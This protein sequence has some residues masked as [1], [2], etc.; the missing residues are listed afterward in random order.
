MS[1][2]WHPILSISG[3][4]SKRAWWSNCSKG[5]LQAL[6]WMNAGYRVEDV[7]LGEQRVTFRKPTADYQVQRVSDIPDARHYPVAHLLFQIG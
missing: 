2:R 4:L 6:A 1:D 5:V 3:L 7:D